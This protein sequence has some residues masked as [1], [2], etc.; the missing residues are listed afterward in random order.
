MNL[1]NNIFFN[2][3]FLSS[4]ITNKQILNLKDKKMFHENIY[5]KINNN[6]QKKNTKLQT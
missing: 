4:L 1:T 6:M 2:V 5:A 3:R